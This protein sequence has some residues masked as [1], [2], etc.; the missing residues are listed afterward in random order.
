MSETDYL[1][2]IPTPGERVLAKTLYDA[3]RDGSKIALG[4]SLFPTFKFED[5]SPE[6][7]AV[8]FHLAR[9][10]IAFLGLRPIEIDPRDCPIPRNYTD[11]PN[12]NG[13]GPNHV[14]RSGGICVVDWPPDEPVV[15]QKRDETEEGSVS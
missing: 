9:T 1:A 2:I 5:I 14:L 12:Y 15:G 10:A 7:M 8:Y 3:Y 13:G 11:G 4:V 6:G